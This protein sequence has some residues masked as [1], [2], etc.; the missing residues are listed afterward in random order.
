MRAPTSALP[1]PG[2]QPLAGRSGLLALVRRSLHVALA[3]VLTAA[4]VE[5]AR[6]DFHAPIA[7]AV[8]RS[9]GTVVLDLSS[10]MERDAP[11]VRRDLDAIERGLAR[12]ERIGLVVFSDS[13]ASTLPATAPRSALARVAR[14]F[15]RSY[16]KSKLR[17]SDLVPQTPWDSSFTGG[18]LISAG[19]RQGELALGRAHLQGGTLYLISDLVDDLDDGAALAK[20][21]A[22][23]KRKGIDIV[24]L[25]I[26]DG[27]PTPFFATLD[28]EVV[29]YRSAHELGRLPVWPIAQAGQPPPRQ[30]PLRLALLVAGVAVLVVLYELVVPR[31]RFRREEIA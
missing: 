14:Y 4:I 13:A 6:T 20:L 12:N 26:P 29:Q 18:T 31:L 27:R 8:I 15:P 23:F 28:P 30:R 16:S 25:R 17:L 1:L 24:I 5:A 21:V 10:S 19:L 2:A 9:G 7:P 3:L 11:L 22:R